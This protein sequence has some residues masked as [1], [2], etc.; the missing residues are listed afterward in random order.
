MSIVACGLSKVG[1]DTFY[2]KSKDGLTVVKYDDNVSTDILS[3]YHWTIYMDSKDTTIPFFRSDTVRIASADPLK[4]EVH[5][6]LNLPP[7]NYEKV[8]DTLVVMD[9]I[10]REMKILRQHYIDYGTSKRKFNPCH[11]PAEA[12]KPFTSKL[13]KDQLEKIMYYIS[14]W[15]FPEES[16]YY[17]TVFNAATRL[18][19]Y[20]KE[21]IDPGKDVLSEHSVDDITT[22]LLLIPS[23]DH[24]PDALKLHPQYSTFIPKWIVYQN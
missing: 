4:P 1:K 10:T 23:P 13:N 16:L 20:R 5:E 14:D 12:A 21:V 9:P 24:F 11:W 17:E 15:R 2:Q 22:Q 8:K 7:G 18:R 6:Y 3:K 19:F